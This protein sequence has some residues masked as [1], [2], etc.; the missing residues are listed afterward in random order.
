[1]V[2]LM[3]IGKDKKQTIHISKIRTDIWCNYFVTEVQEQDE[4]LQCQSDYDYLS[5]E[6]NNVSY[7]DLFD[8]KIELNLQPNKE[9]EIK[10]I[11]VIEDDFEYGTCIDAIPTIIDIKPC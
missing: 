5:E 8:S 11:I 6:L 4:D 9:Y 10:W 7:N 2:I 3:I 1:M